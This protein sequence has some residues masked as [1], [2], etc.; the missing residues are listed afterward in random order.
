MS[1]QFNSIIVWRRRPHRILRRRCAHP[2]R[3]RVPLSEFTDQ[4]LNVTVV[5]RLAAQPRVDAARHL[6]DCAGGSGADESA[7]DA[8]THKTA[9]FP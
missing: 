7:S 6:L 8:P 3:S 4:R 1:S 2:G 9:T 5:R